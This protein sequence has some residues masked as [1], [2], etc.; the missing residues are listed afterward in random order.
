MNK[1]RILVWALA[2]LVVGSASGVTYASQNK[3]VTKNV[4]VTAENK[5]SSNTQNKGAISDEEAVKMATEAMKSYM[6]KDVS[7]FSQT[8]IVRSSD[9]RRQIKEE[10][11]KYAKEHPEEAK[12]LEEANKKYAQEHPEEAKIEAENIAKLKEESTIDVW[13]VPKSYDESKLWSNFVS[14]NEKTGEVVNVTAINGL[15]KNSDYQIDDAK[16]KD[17][18]LNFIQKIGK[19]IQGSSIRVDKDVDSDLLPVHFKLSDGKEAEI[20]IN[21]KDYSV[22]H[23]SIQYNDV[24]PMTSSKPNLS[25][26]VIVGNKNVD[27]IN[28]NK[29]RE[30]QIN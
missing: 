16:V 28:D 19:K 3:D 9:T 21:L 24:K 5:I 29:T 10:S 17:A 6:G 7:Y 4:V 14:I 2:L 18:T 8:K 27:Q 11:E 23:Y 20:E 22:V 15:E 13:F 1:K 30:I 26:K 25:K 12:K